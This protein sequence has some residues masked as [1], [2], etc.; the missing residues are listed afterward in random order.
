MVK[1]NLVSIDM[2]KFDKSIQNVID[3]LSK[4]EKDVDGEIGFLTYQAGSIIIGEAKENHAF[5]SRTGTLRRSL[6]VA[7]AGLGHRSDK[8]NAIEGID[9][10]N[11]A[12]PNIKIEGTMVNLELGS[13]LEYAYPTEMGTH[14]K[15][16]KAYPYLLPAFEK[17]FDETVEF[18]AKGLRIILESSGI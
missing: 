15:G 8:R 16:G 1:D 14:H 13:W 18:I 7:P 9:L 12:R 6:H 11:E 5:T 10:S 3:K 2:R 4:L 17:K